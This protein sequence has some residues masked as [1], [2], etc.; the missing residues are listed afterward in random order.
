MF[1]QSQITVSIIQKIKSST[2]FQLHSGVIS[3]SIFRRTEQRSLITNNKFM[4]F[5]A[6]I[7]VCDTNT[8]IFYVPAEFSYNFQELNSEIPSPGLRFTIFRSRTPNDKIVGK[9]V[10]NLTS[11]SRRK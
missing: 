11:K 8:Y 5:D 10:L 1:L 9:K 2:N 6:H 7:K 4:T 3:K